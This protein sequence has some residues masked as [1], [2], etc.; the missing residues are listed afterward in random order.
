MVT[1][2]EKVRNTIKC[3]EYRPINTLRTCEKN[4]EKIVNN[5][6]EEYFQKPSLLSKDQSDFSNRYSWK[7]AI[8]YV[9][10]RWNFIG[11]DC[12]VL[13]ILWISKELSKQ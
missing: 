13:A 2:V 12:K 6:L 4:I 1:L 9:I 8:N 10:N 5:Q 11:N 3:E 7:T